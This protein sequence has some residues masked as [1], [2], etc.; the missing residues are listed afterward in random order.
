MNTYVLCTESRLPLTLQA[1][2][3][4]QPFCTQMPNNERSVC[5][6]FPVISTLRLD[7]QEKSISNPVVLGKRLS[8]SYS[9]ISTMT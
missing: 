6:V 8:I 4:I 3:G 1:P 5:I 9:D 2:S 7:Q